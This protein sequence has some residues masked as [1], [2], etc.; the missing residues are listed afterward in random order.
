MYVEAA[1]RVV[2]SLGP[3]KGFEE[4]GQHEQRE[5]KHLKSLPKRHLE[6]DS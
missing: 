2:S 6:D 5:E 3:D 1:L 4:E